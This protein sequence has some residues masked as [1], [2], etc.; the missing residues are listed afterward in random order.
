MYPTAQNAFAG[1]NINTLKL[2]SEAP[3]TCC[4]EHNV[5]VQSRN[6]YDI[7]T[8]CNLHIHR[9]RKNG[10]ILHA[11]VMNKTNATPVRE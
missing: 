3:N 4:V 9:T 6:S 8:T 5:S 7:S 2:I 10:R 11:N 1:N